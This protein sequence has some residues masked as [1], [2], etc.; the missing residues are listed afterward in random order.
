MSL[1]RPPR[2]G[3]RRST[4]PLTARAGAARSACTWHTRRRGSAAR[5]VAATAPTGQHP[6]SRAGRPQS[7]CRCLFASKTWEPR[8][9]AQ[10]VDL[11]GRRNLTHGLQVRTSADRDRGFRTVRPRGDGAAERRNDHR[12]ELELG[13]QRP[14]AAQ[15]IGRRGRAPAD[16]RGQQVRVRDQGIERRR[17]D[18]RDLRF[19][20]ARAT[21]VGE[22][23]SGPMAGAIALAVLLLLGGVRRWAAS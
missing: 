1:A 7:A 19:G 14:D 11:A 8:A 2:A 22:T 23:A 9:I 3:P 20:E 10:R 5:Q 13:R 18:A 6:R 16:R 4:Q 17:Q 21:P 12:I 15:V